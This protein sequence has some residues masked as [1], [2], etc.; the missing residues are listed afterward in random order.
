MKMKLSA[1]IKVMFLSMVFVTMLACSAWAAQAQVDIRHYTDAALLDGVTDYDPNVP[2]LDV[3]DLLPPGVDWMPLPYRYQPYCNWMDVLLH[4]PDVVPSDTKITLDAD[5][6]VPVVW[7]DSTG[8]NMEGFFKFSGPKEFDVLPFMRWTSDPKPGVIS[9]ASGN[10]YGLEGNAE[11]AL[12]GRPFSVKIAGISDLSGLLPNIRTTKQQLDNC[13]PFVSLTRDS[14]GKVTGFTL[15]FVKSSDTNTALTCDD[16]KPILTMYTIRL[17]N[18]PDFNFYNIEPLNEGDPMVY[19]VNFADHSVDSVDLKEFDRLSV[20]FKYLEDDTEDSS[21]AYCWRF[22]NED[23]NVQRNDNGGVEIIPPMPDELERIKDELGQD[24]DIVAA[25]TASLQSHTSIF[26]NLGEDEIS[27]A[28]SSAILIK[29]TLPTKGGAAVVGN[30]VFA[31]NPTSFGGKP[32]P[33]ANSFA[34]LKANYDVLKYFEKGGAIDLLETFGE[35]IFT[36][37]PTDKKLDLTAT[38]VV[39]DGSAPKD[40]KITPVFDRY[41]VRL[42]DNKKYLY[43]Y[44]GYEN[45]VASDPIALVAKQNSG[46]DDGNDDNGNQNDDTPNDGNTSNGGGCNTGYGMA[47]LLLAGLVTI[48][49]R[50]A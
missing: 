2:P 30:P 22:H 42:S 7:Y 6:E 48:K 24:I 21:I 14:N 33:V 15:R 40:E 18:Q 11:T 44:D 27:A 17:S 12:S 35:D 29:Q 38:V 45:G 16:T 34:E 25:E 41:G 10:K 20:Y 1:R 49:R 13:A 3:T 47:V 5:G 46:N 37:S 8:D 4:F 32:I 26:I 31:M 36:Y 39:I 28:T 23:E 9:S 50:K 43:I 19:N